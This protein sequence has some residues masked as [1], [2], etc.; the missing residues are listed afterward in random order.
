MIAIINKEG[1]LELTAET[2]T[3]DYALIMW[4]KSERKIKG[5]GS[6]KQEV[7]NSEVLEDVD[8][9]TPTDI[10]DTTV[11]KRTPN[12]EKKYRVELRNKL[13]A[14]KVAFNARATT[15]NL[16]RLLAEAEANAVNT[17]LQT[18]D[19]ETSTDTSVV[20]PPM[21]A[22][23][24]KTLFST[25]LAIKGAVHENGEKRG[26]VVLR[27]FGSTNLTGLTEEKRAGFITFLQKET[28]V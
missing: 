22:E 27:E 28:N 10:F 17:E 24:L 21:D 20:K 11:G 23:G 4:T 12:E 2:P 25:Y 3:E 19:A 13:T 8:D 1:E 14:H 5:L 6:A 18:D 15:E 16:E 9:G 26:I 7:E